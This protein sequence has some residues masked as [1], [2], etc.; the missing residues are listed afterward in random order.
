MGEA[1]RRLAARY[2]WSGSIA[3]FSEKLRRGSLRYREALELADVLGYEL[4]WRRRG[5]AQNG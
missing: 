5:E 2:E 3:N 4:V 1:V